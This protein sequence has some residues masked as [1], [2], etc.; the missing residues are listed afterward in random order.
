MRRQNVKSLVGGRS[1]RSRRSGTAHRL[2]ADEFPSGAPVP[3]AGLRSIGFSHPTHC[4]AA[5]Q[6]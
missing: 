5:A 2:G 3:S 4:H 6:S 1:A